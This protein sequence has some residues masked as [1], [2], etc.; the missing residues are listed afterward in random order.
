MHHSTVFYFFVWD[1]LHDNDIVGGSESESLRYSYMLKEKG[2]TSQTLEIVLCGGILSGKIWITYF[3]YSK[4]MS[5]LISLL[6]DRLHPDDFKIVGQTFDI[7]GL[8]RPA[9]LTTFVIPYRLT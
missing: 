3:M 4:L 8:H 9:K 1:R 7:I 6:V 5:Q 2:G